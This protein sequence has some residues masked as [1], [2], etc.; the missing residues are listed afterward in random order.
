MKCNNSRSLD[1]VITPDCRLCSVTTGTMVDEVHLTA[2]IAQ[3]ADTKRPRIL[4]DAGLFAYTNA[5]P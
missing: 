2:T 5:A 3:T 1:I 4:T